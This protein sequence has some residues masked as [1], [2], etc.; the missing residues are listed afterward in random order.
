MAKYTEIYMKMEKDKWYLASELGVAPATMTAMVNRG[1]VE[2]TDT[3]PR[4]YHKISSVLT[5]V[6]SI[7]KNYNVEFFGLQKEGAAIG[8][9][10][11][12]DKER[13][14]DCW[15]NPYDLTGVNRL[16]IRGEIFEL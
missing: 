6:L 9:L 1:L 4:K 16:D 11:Y 3:S 2:K 5:T 14:M 15:G 12:L 8:M 13:I 7:L 10:C